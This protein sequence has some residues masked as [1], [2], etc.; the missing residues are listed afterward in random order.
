[1]MYIDDKTIR[2]L[3]EHVE[4]KQIE[5]KD[6]YVAL[7]LSL[8]I[9]GAGQ[10][11]LGFYG[12]GFLII[13]F[14]CVGYALFILPGGILAVF[15]GIGAMNYAKTINQ[16]LAEKEEQTTKSEV[17]NQKQRERT[18][19]TATFVEHIS[20]IHKLYKNE[21][22]SEREFLDKKTSYISDLR[23]S[24][25]AENYEDFLLGIA[26]LK[27]SGAITKEEVEQIKTLVCSK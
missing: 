5:K 13:V 8:I 20:K 11:Y 14:A 16:I 26:S 17:E 2:Q 21:I 3:R 18:I 15:S 22:I 6:P 4:K 25:I 9:P 10:I 1:M 7:A 27:E 24:Y 12:L 23:N 19:S